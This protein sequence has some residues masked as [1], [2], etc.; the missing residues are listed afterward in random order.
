MTG[1]PVGGPTDLEGN[2]KM[3]EFQEV[4]FD[5]REPSWPT[6]GGW[7]ELQHMP[8]EREEALIAEWRSEA[9]RRVLLP[10]VLHDV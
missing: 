4:P 5:P 10:W 6:G 2:P 8:F 3:V 7:S 1:D 9:F